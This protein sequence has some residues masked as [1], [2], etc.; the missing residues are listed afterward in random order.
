MKS[1]WIFATILTVAY[2]IYY[3]VNIARDLYGKKGQGKADEEVFELDPDDEQ[4]RVAVTESETGFSV[5]SEMYK[6]DYTAVPASVPQD[7]AESENTETAEER[8]ARIKAKTEASMEDTVPY[9][10]DV[11]TAEE[12][13]KA[14]V[15]G[16][17]LDNRPEMRW[18]PVNDKL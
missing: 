5:G 2:V 3:A 12:M 14:M 7:A 10:S 16:G 18:K 9:L 15:S 8:F 1:Y 4:D 6:T 11:Y 17:R 13:Y